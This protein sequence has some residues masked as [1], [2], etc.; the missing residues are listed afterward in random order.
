M[1]IESLWRITWPKRSQYALHAFTLQSGGNSRNKLVITIVMWHSSS[2]IIVMLY[3]WTASVLV[4][5]VV[6]LPTSHD[7]SLRSLRVAS[8]AREHVFVIWCMRCGFIKMNNNA[9]RFQ[10]TSKP[11]PVVV[12]LN[13]LQMRIT[14]NAHFHVNGLNRANRLRCASNANWIRYFALAL[15][16]IFNTS[17][18]QRIVTTCDCHL[19]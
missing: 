9:I 12:W 3:Q 16:T 5:S 13:A 4:A 7:S 14:A 15:F 10:F 2:I 8:G 11:P 6:C 1:R 18:L 17:V 19:E